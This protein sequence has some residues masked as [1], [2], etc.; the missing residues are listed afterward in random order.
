MLPQGA[1]AAGT[2][3]VAIVET[4]PSLPGPWSFAAKLGQALFII[5][6]IVVIGGL[7]LL[8]WIFVRSSFSRWIWQVNRADLACETYKK[9]C[10]MGAMMKI[11]PRPQQTPLEYMAVLAAE[12][13]EQAQELQEITRAYLERQFG[14]RKG[15]QDLFNEARLLK[16]RRRLFDKLMSRLS[17]VE[18]I[19]RGR[20]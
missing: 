20:L 12:F 4:R 1:G 9:I 6:S 11:G 8:L 18:K 13:P 14:G 16:A 3:G 7:L 19:F 10:Q 2:G 5:L 17:Q 15:K